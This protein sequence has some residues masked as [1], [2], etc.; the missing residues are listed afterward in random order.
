MSL[1]RV[2]VNG[3]ETTQ[4]SVF[5]RGLSYGDGFFTTALVD[6]GKWLNAEAHWWRI[7]QSCCKLALP[8]I[9]K[10]ILL[11]LL[12]SSFAQ[13]GAEQGQ[14]LVLKLVITRGQGGRG[15]QPPEQ[16]TPT[17]ITQWMQSPIDMALPEPILLRQCQTPLSMNAALA[18]IKHLNRLDNV[19][20]KAELQARGFEEGLLENAFGQVVCSSQA[21]LFLLDGNVLLTPCLTQSGVY[22]TVRYALAKICAEI[23][24]QW[25][26][27]DISWQQIQQADAIFLS[28]AI[29]GIMPVSA[30]EFSESG[31][32]KFA[33]QHFSKIAEIAK[34]FQDYQQRTAL[35]LHK[36]SDK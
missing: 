19:R 6:Q 27:A 22:G 23:G 7:E 4:I 34:H 20:A 10:D 2:W 9:D 12:Q 5:D 14:L 8:P 18:G 21:N 17:V 24:Y 16:C 1:P 26:E 35:D 36:M 13:L 11:T 31:L 29:R 25:Q 15:Y 30:V 28:N 32:H 3:Q 33:T